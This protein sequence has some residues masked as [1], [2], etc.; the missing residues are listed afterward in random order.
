M[1]ERKFAIM[2]GVEWEIEGEYIGTFTRNEEP[3]AFPNGTRV[4]KVKCD[5]D[6]DMNPVGALGSVLG[7]FRIPNKPIFYFIEWDAFPKHAVGVLDWKIERHDK[8]N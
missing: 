7:S 4:V 5:D 1:S 6:R 3:D 2:G 8:D